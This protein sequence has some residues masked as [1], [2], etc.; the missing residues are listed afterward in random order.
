MCSDNIIVKNIFKIYMA[1]FEKYFYEHDDAE[2]ISQL[3]SHEL[4]LQSNACMAFA[5]IWG[6]VGA[7]SDF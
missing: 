7:F 1:Y 2:S 3:N 6:Y 4:E 5:T